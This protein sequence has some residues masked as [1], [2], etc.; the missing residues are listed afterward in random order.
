MF[1]MEGRLTHVANV[2]S[3]PVQLLRYRLHELLAIATLC[4]H[5]IHKTFTKHS[6]NIYAIIPSAEQFI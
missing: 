3:H 2:D 4:M 1:L 5:N 6:Q